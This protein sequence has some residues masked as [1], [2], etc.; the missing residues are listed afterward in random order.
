VP[1][2]GLSKNFKIV[3]VAIIAV[4][5]IA[6]TGFIIINQLPQSNAPNS[7]P[8]PTPSPTV[9]QTPITT[10]TPTPVPTPTSS[11]TTN[12]AIFDFDIGTPTLSAYATT[13]FDQTNNGLTAHFSSTV[14]TSAFSIQSINSLSSIGG[15]I[16]SQKLSGNFLWP[17]SVNHDSLNIQFSSNIHKI[18]LN[19]KTAE[20][21]DPGVGSTGSIIRISAFFDSTA[22]PVGSPITTRGIENNDVYP[23][24][25]LSIDLAGL[26]FNQVI[27]DLP[28]PTGASGFIIDNIVV[29]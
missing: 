25:N 17:N 19:F 6:I 23:E 16:N 8:T 20:L 4:I 29:S 9:S 18:A 15:V 24:G 7:T 12:S 5:A 14:S 27:I 1:T 26:S 11:P 3:I 21:N 13:P 2:S 22:N 10:S 28:T